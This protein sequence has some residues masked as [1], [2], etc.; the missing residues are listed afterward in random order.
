MMGDS[1]ANLTLQ[2]PT[3]AT[4]LKE[5]MIIAKGNW[6]LMFP[7]QRFGLGSFT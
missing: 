4:V 7:F 1:E 6:L 5:Q 2:P 3:P